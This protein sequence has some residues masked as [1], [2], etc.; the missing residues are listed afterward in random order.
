[1][2]GLPCFFKNRVALPAISCGDLTLYENDIQQTLK[3]T[4]IRKYSFR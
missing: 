4:E 3:N 2:N 1:M